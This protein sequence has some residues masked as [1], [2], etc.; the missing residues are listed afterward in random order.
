MWLGLGF[1]KGG[2]EYSQQ[3]QHQSTAVPRDVTHN[4]SKEGQ[5]NSTSSKMDEEEAIFTPH[6]KSNW[7]S[8]T[9]ES[10]SS[11]Q[12]NSDLFT[13]F[14]TFSTDSGSSKRFVVEKPSNPEKKQTMTL[15]SI[16]EVETLL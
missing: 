11:I 7:K 5:S 1:D 10:S 15:D 2:V 13:S 8:S 14:A 16:L 6:K 4:D 9:T 3:E 12:F